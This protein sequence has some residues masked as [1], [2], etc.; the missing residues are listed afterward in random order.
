MECWSRKPTHSL[1]DYTT[2]QPR[3]ASLSVNNQ[4]VST[5]QRSRDILQTMSPALFFFSSSFLRSSIFSSNV[6]PA[7]CIG[8][9]LTF[10][11]GRGG[12]LSPHI[13]STRLI[14]TP[15]RAEPLFFLIFSANFLASATYYLA[16]VHE[17]N[18]TVRTSSNK[19]RIYAYGF[20][21]LRL[22]GR[23]RWH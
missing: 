21:P 15:T 12:R 7:N 5:A 23:P 14:L 20:L 2:K 13:E 3:P 11:C 6:F 9:V 17:P 10:S 18:V 16:P 1:A 4:W 8:S 22:V 19:C